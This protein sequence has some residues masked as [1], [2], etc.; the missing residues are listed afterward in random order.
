MEKLT[1]WAELNTLRM[2]MSRAHQLNRREENLT[3]AWT[4]S[5]A[6]TP[7][8][9]A[10]IARIGDAYRA[11][12]ASEQAAGNSMWLAFM[13]ENLAMHEALLCGDAAHVASVF[14]DP[15][16]TNQFIGFDAIY[17]GCL[18]WM[19]TDGN[20]K[21]WLARQVYDCLLRTAEA[22]GVIRLENP[23]QYHAD[24]PR[25]LDV[26][27]VL[28]KL[29]RAFGFP[30][31][32]PNPY[33]NECGIESSRGLVGYRAIQGLFQAW[34][35]AELLKG[36]RSAR[37]LEIGAGLG[38]TAF[39]AWSFGIKDYT[40]VDLP[41][42]NTSQAHYLGTTLGADA[43]SLSGEP[44]C[45]ETIKISTADSFHATAS[46]F[47]L[48]LNVDSFTEID[49]QMAQGYWNAIES[50]TPLLLSINHEHNAFT[51]RDFI[52]KSKA[53]TR[54]TRTPYWLRPGYVEEIVEFQSI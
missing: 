11:S 47:D 29:D 25:L 4:L 42:T 18:Q 52:E 30:I 53:V 24:P 28:Q 20:A 23:E 48:V 16:R 39:Y 38:R 54:S 1:D 49:E 2:R 40:I 27:E 46:K 22:V 37:V 35:M 3:I 17:L 31:K 36:R 14:V 32:F 34:R 43:I 7:S 5:E 19:A 33:P 6:A 44:Q 9:A 21:D 50:R 10:L 41:F 15:A 12:G 8:D 26:D 51:V 45:L 13:R